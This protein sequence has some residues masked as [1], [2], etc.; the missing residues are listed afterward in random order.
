M[1]NSKIYNN[2]NNEK[3][4]IKKNNY[5]STWASKNVVSPAIDFSSQTTLISRNGN[6]SNFCIENINNINFLQNK[7]ICLEINKAVDHSFIPNNNINVNNLD[8]IIHI[9]DDKHDLISYFN[10]IE[11]S[12]VH[13]EE[14]QNALQINNINVNSFYTNNDIF[15]K[16][17]SSCNSTFNNHSNVHEWYTKCK[18]YF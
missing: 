9:I 13:D 6:N 10:F 18:S 11:Q 3:T 14:V 15:E 8:T 7:N 17:D 1:R 4:A 16:I 5:T 12:N 2:Y